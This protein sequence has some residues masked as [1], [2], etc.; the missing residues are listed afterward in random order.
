MSLD[1]N[2]TR[3][4]DYDSLCFEEVDGVREIKAR[5]DAMIWSSMIVG[6]DKITSENCKEFYTRVAMYERIFG[7]LVRS[8][9]DGV[10]NGIPCTLEHVQQHIGMSTNADNLT[11]LQFDKQIMKRLRREVK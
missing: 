4:A 5:T 9:V 8:Y 2:L 7:P 10:R 11:A 3:I 6:I 1:F